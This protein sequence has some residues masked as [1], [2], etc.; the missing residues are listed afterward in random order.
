[1]MEGSALLSPLFAIWQEE[2]ALAGGRIAE[3][4]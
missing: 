2:K 3:T 1:M 4:G